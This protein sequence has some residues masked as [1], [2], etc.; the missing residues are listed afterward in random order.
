[1]LAAFEVGDMAEPNE[2]GRPTQSFDLTH[3]MAMIP[4][5]EA[6]QAAVQEMVPQLAAA[7]RAY[8]Q[9]KSD[10]D[11]LHLD[12]VQ[13]EASDRL[14]TL[15]DTLARA[16]A[17][18]GLPPEMFEDMGTPEL[19]GDRT[20]RRRRATLTVDEV[21]P[22]AC[23]DDS[24]AE[25]LGNVLER[26]PPGWLEKEPADRFRLPDTVVDRPF[27]IVKGFRP[28]SE[29]PSGHRLRQMIYVAQDRLAGR[30]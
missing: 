1:M 4:E 11:R 18:S 6:A 24:L 17:A 13:R 9:S 5:L 2:P 16:Q 10:Q 12:E 27:S 28:E 22:T 25:A 7:R 19:R 8:A 30:L 21:E 29:R 20:D 26:L 14:A 15:N 3:A 23:V